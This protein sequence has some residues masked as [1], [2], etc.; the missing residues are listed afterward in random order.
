MFNVCPIG[1][2]NR[3]PNINLENREKF[4]KF[5]KETNYRKNILSYLNEKLKLMIID[6]QIRITYGG[7]TSFD[8]GVLGEDKTKPIKELVSSKQYDRIIFIGD[9]LYENGND[10]VIQIYIDSWPYFNNNTI[11]PVEAISVKDYKET[12]NILKEY[13]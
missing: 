11:C 9:A 4:I 3:H 13:T 10:Y 1:R 6:R 7:Q 2:D 12:M 5:D 8:I